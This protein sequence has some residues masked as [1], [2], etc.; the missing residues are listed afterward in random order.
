MTEKVV[1]ASESLFRPANG[2]RSTRSL[3]EIHNSYW[4]K[5]FFQMTV[6]VMFWMV[7]CSFKKTKKTC[8]LYFTEK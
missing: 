8:S 5:I 4:F 6:F 3:V 2:V 7:T 1:L